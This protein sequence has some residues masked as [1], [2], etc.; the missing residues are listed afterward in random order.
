MQRIHL[1]LIE[2]AKE[3]LGNDSLTTADVA[4]ALGFVYPQ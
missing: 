1:K 4:N 2:K 3:M